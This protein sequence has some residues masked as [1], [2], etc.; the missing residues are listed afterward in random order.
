MGVIETDRKYVADT[1]ARQNVVFVRGKGATL[2]DRWGN[3]YI[4]FGAG[5]A[6]NGLGIGFGKWRRAVRSQLKALPHASNLYYT[7]PCADLAKLLCRRTGMSSGERIME[8]AWIPR[9]PADPMCSPTGSPT[10]P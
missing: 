5:I 8:P 4:D 9:F 1:Y 6:V 10:Y 2:V 7:Q 3:K